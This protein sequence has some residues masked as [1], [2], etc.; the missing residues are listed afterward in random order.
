MIGFLGLAAGEE[1]CERGLEGIGGF[2]VAGEH[3]VL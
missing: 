3:G 2:D 1:V